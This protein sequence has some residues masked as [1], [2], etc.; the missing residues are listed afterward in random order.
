MTFK[1]CRCCGLDK[2]M[3]AF[4]RNAKRP[5]GLQDH[6]KPCRSEAAAKAW[7]DF[8]ASFVGPL[9]PHGLRR[10]R[11]ANA[12]RP[13]PPATPKRPSPILAGDGRPAPKRPKPKTPP[14]PSMAP[15]TAGE[16]A[17]AE[18][19][20]AAHRASAAVAGNAAD[21]QPKGY[22]KSN[23]HRIAEAE[24]ARADGVGTG[25]ECQA[26]DDLARRREE[27]LAAAASLAASVAPVPRVGRV[28]FVP[29]S[30]S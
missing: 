26:S 15:M 11:A 22:R 14:P 28:A 9:W 1:H 25:P 18:A 4:G 16:I 8:R 23:F 6:C 29:P 20:I 10:D 5:D 24:Q 19:I 13:K 27:A 12:G 17:Q 21:S 3:D 30:R 7:A 2:P